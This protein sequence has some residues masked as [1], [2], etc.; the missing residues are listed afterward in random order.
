MTNTKAA[1]CISLSFLG[2]AA[3]GAAVI[4]AS[5]PE[6]RRKMANALEQSRRM[7]KQ[8]PEAIQDVKTIATDALLEARE[9]GKAALR[10]AGEVAKQVIEVS[11]ALRNS[12]SV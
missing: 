1:V 4:Y 6:N 10:D 2:G 12:R 5:N 3:V 11:P 9:N 8:V 7:A